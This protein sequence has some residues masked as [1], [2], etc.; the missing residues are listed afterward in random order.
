MHQS[1]TKAT[2]QYIKCTKIQSKSPK[3]NTNHPQK[4]L[5]QTTNKINPYLQMYQQ[6]K[7]VSNIILPQ[8]T[9]YNP[10]QHTKT[11][12]Q[13]SLQRYNHQPNKPIIQS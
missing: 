13:P 1:I 12:Y 10:N 3:P 8:L 4:N 2:I 9:K 7:Q 5:I 6:N 11:Q